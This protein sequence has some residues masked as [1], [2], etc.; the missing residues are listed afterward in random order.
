M[1]CS[2]CQD[3]AQYQTPDNLCEYHWYATF[4]LAEYSRE[5]LEQLLAGNA[6]NNMEREVAADLLGADL[7]PGD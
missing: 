2:Y 5:E 4:W 3:V 7:K 1:R 6:A